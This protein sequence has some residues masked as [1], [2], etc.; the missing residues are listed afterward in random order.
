MSPAIIAVVAVGLVGAAIWRGAFAR[1][2]NAGRERRRRARFVPPPDRPVE[3]QIVGQDF[4]DIPEVRDI[5]DN[6]LAISVPHRFNGHKPT[7]EVDLLLT[8]HGQGTL[9]ARGAIRHASYS[10]SDTATFGVELVDIK[11]EDR[12]KLRAYLAEIEKA[13]SKGSR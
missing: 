12:A 6:G 10:R 1:E 7:Q 5:S 13:G 9:R 4:L 8:L 11:D 2:A 3:L